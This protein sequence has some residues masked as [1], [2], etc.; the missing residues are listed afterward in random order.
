[1]TSPGPASSTQPATAPGLPV[2]IVGGGLS[3]LAAGVEL[4]SRGVPILLLEQKSS[5]GGR[6][7]SFKDSTTGD[8]IDNGQHV[9]LA[10]YTETLKFLETIGARALLDIQTRPSLL[11]H[12]PLKGFQRFRI[13]NLPAPLNLL[14]GILTF[15]VLSWVDRVRM[16]RAGVAIRRA[17]STPALRDMTIEQWLDSVGQ[18]AECKRSFWVPLAISVMNE[19]ID[20]AAAL[21]FV[22]ALR[23]AFLTRRDHA[24]LAIPR[25][26]LSDLYVQPAQRYITSRGGDIRCDASVRQLMFNGELITGVRRVDG[27]EHACSAVILAVPSNKCT[28][29]IPAGLLEHRQFTAMQSVPSSPIVSVHL[30]FARDFMHDEVVGLIGRTVQWLFNRRKINREQG[31]GGHVSAVIS[32][33]YEVVSYPNEELIRLVMEDLRSVY[34]RQDEEPYHAVVI[35]EKRATFSST[36]QIERLRPAQKTPVPNLFLAGDWTDTGFPATIESAVLSARCC[37]QYAVQ[38]IAGERQ[39]Q[40]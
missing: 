10:G 15:R 20:R 16:I 37:S 2:I 31:K 25:V 35:R 28:G 36:P 17:E 30:W 8:T 38:W 29:V 18:S 9:L 22:H 33:A 1:M 34:P 12:H 3:G 5:L 39:G 4:T 13:P 27:D 40:H 32:A 21:T 26:G 11:L 6:A 24:S 23:V 14:W 7:Y 19:Q